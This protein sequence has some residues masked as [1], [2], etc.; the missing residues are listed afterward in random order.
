MDGGLF[1]ARQPGWSA[2]RPR[3]G[4]LRRNG[5]RAWRAE[6]DRR[7]LH[8]QYRS[9]NR[10]HQ[11]RRNDRQQP[12]PLRGNH[13]LYGQHLDAKRPDGACH[14]HGHGHTAD[15]GQHARLQRAPQRRRTAYCWRRREHR[16]GATPTPTPTPTPTITPTPTPIG[17]PTPTPTP[18][19]TTPTPTPTGTP[20]PTNP[21][22]SVS[23][24]FLITVQ[25]SITGIT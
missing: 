13:L 5:H 4:V 3:G 6:R 15:D 22:S 25:L 21:I 2:H 20:T 12:G 8:P 18:T 9:A 17:T 24:S 10:F 1:A 7:Y 19:P 11:C 14:G 16:R 23:S